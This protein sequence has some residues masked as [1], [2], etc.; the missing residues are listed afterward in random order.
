MKI[1]VV[2]R[3]VVKYVVVVAVAVFVV[4][5]LYD[6]VA[7]FVLGHDLFYTHKTKTKQ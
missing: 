4:V 5:S 6:K 3:V 2:V 1:R 7:V